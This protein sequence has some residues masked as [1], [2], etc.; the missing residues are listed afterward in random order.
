MQGRRLVE[1]E[2]IGGPTLGEFVRELRGAAGLGQV[3]LA[4]ALAHVSGCTQAA[5]SRL[6]NDLW[7]PDAGQLEHLLRT[8]RATETE[9]RTARCLAAALSVR[10]E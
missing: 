9:A 3:Q 4:E 6:E 10:G 7:L 2:N 8:L 1:V 5:I